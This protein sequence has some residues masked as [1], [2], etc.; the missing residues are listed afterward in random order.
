M[1]E[2][3]PSKRN[4]A[5]GR[6]NGDHTVLAAGYEPPRITNYVRKPLD[7]MDNVMVRGLG[8]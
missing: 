6:P 1:T 8:E 3:F 4:V 2:Q 5:T 7:V